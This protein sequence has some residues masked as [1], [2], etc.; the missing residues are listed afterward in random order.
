MGLGR[1]FLAAP[2]CFDEAWAV[3]SKGRPGQRPCA[4]R[5]TPAWVDA[6]RRRLKSQ[7]IPNN[8]RNAYRLSC[9]TFGS[10]GRTSVERY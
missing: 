9:A 3:A 10:I 4:G 7:S 1:R 6:D 8:A 2:P 5:A